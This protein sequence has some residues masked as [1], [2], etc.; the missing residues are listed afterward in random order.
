MFLKMFCVGFGV[1]LGFVAAAIC[2][3]LLGEIISGVGK[4]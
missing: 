3:S 4:K 2:V 1:T